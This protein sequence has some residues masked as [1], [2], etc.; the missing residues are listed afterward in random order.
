M[1]IIIMLEES[2][3][4]KRDNLSVCEAKAVHL[5]NKAQS[6]NENGLVQNTFK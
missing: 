6:R 1:R 2:K 4:W 5:L 3:E